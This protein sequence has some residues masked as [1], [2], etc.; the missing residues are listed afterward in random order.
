MAEDEIKQRGDHGLGQCIAPGDQETHA[1]VQTLGRIR[2]EPRG[3]RQVLGQLPDRDRDEQAADEREQHRQRKR[4]AGE[5]GAHDDG[6]GDGGARRHV[7]DGLE[8]DLSHTNRI[9]RQLATYRGFS[10]DDSLSRTMGSP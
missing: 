1:G 10:H 3:R 5:P 7:S 9:V 8:K 6:E 2:C 4:P